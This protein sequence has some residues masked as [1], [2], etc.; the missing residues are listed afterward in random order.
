MCIS[1]APFMFLQAH[2]SAKIAMFYFSPHLLYCSLP[3]RVRRQSCTLGLYSTLR[4]TLCERA[5]ACALSGAG[6][7]PAKPVSLFLVTHCGTILRTQSISSAPS[8]EVS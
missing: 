1:T 5:S 7:E 8:E 3:T 2:V 4:T 6:G